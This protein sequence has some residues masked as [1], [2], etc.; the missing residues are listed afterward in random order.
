MKFDNTTNW[1]NGPRKIIRDY[2]DHWYVSSVVLENTFGLDKMY[3]RFFLF[4][5]LIQYD[6]FNEDDY[7]CN[8]SQERYCRELVRDYLNNYKVSERELMDYF[9]I[10]KVKNHHYLKEDLYTRNRKN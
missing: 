8:S 6:E 1:G 5:E 3:D 2:L 4:E 9:N 7:K 10:V